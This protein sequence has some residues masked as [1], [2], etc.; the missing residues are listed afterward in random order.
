MRGQ[1]AKMPRSHERISPGRPR[2]PGCRTSEGPRIVDR[3][4]GIP[5]RTMRLAGGHSRARNAEPD[6]ASGVMSG[7][8]M[9]GHD[10]VLVT[11]LIN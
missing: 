11:D 6:R 8:V 3:A 10:A 9:T 5:P 1:K 7:G 4:L 2:R